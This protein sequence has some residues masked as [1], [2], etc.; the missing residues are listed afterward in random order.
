MA[1]CD[2]CLHKPVCAKYT[3][4]G[5]HVKACNHLLE[6]KAGR[7]EEWY[8]P[9]HMILTGEE[10]LYRCTVCDAKYSDVAGYRHCPYCGNPM[11]G[12]EGDG[13]HLL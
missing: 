13:N 2:N 3:A 4:T 6:R 8:P 1:A 10:M 9:V 11:D 7:W 5:G 12:G